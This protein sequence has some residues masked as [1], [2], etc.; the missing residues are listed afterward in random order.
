ML[1]ACNGQGQRVY[2]YNM[3]NPS[4]SYFCP[5]CHESLIFVN[6]RVK[7]KHFRHKVESKCSPEPETQMHLEMK[8]F[9]LSYFGWDE[10]NLEV[11]LGFARPDLFKDGVAIEVQ[12]SPLSYDKFIERTSNY[13]KHDIH[14]LWIFHESLVKQNIPRFIKKA[15]EIYFG[16]VYVF[17]AKAF[18]P[19]HLERLWKWIEPNEFSEHDGYLKPYKSKRYILM[20]PHINNSIIKKVFNNWKDNCYTLAMFNDGMFWRSQ[21]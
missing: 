20:G 4:D 8:Q 15:H 5:Y 1:I 3:K 14:V 21:G 6:A 10:T 9:A 12:Y 13:K 19:I 2:S 11:N 17:K 16:R 18:Y 7:I